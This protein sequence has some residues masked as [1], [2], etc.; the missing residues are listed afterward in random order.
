VAVTTANQRAETLLGR[1][2]ERW[3]AVGFPDRPPEAA[4]AGRHCMLDWLGC[5]LAGSRGL[6]TPVIGAEPAERLRR[7]VTDLAPARSLALLSRGHR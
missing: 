6:A 7:A 2:A 4:K 5:A 3:S 1:L